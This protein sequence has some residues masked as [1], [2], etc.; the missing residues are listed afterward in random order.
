MSLYLMMRRG[1]KVFLLPPARGHEFFCPY[2]IFGTTS[3]VPSIA[4]FE[5]MR[6]SQLTPLVIVTRPLIKPYVD[7]N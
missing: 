5:S 7:S 4:P 2:T 3:R 1:G 6:Y